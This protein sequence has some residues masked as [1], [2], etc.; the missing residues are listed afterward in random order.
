MLPKIIKLLK[1]YNQLLVDELSEL[2]D[3]D[4]I[5]QQQ[6]NKE[7]QGMYDLV[8]LLSM[9]EERGISLEQLMDAVKRK[10]VG[11]TGSL[12]VQTRQY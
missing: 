9:C 12:F 2:K 3:L 1:V 8:K 6:I 4:L 11:S 7:C 10:K 5:E